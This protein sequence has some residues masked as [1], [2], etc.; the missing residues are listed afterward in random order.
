[1]TRVDEIIGYATEAKTAIEAIIDCAYNENPTEL[2]ALI[3]E[4]NDALRDLRFLDIFFD[5]SEV[6]E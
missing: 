6:E 4:A 2:A 3:E 1:M 5:D